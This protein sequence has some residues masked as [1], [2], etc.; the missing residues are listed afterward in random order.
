MAGPDRVSAEAVSVP[1]MKGAPRYSLL[2]NSEDLC[3][4]PQRAIAAFTAQNGATLELAPK[5]ADQLRGQG[6]RQAPQGQEG[7]P[8]RALRVV[9]RS[10]V[11]RSGCVTKE[12]APTPAADRAMQ[13]IGEAL[14]AR[15]AGQGSRP[16][17]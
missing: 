6:P 13:G 15:H 4:T 12:E 3:R 2:E 5:I 10:M 17:G 9:L 16:A 8:R 14:V 11:G 1:E 7:P